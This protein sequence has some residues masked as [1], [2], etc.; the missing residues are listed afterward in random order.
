MPDQDISIGTRRN[1]L[2]NGISLHV[3]TVLLLHEKMDSTAQS[4]GLRQRTDTRMEI[5][6]H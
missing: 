5:T 1:V 4:H 3:D 2:S 6:Q